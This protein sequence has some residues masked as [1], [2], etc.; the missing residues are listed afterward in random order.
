M[1]LSA[2]L[3]RLRREAGAVPAGQGRPAGDVAD[4][5]ARLRR[6]GVRRAGDG[7]ADDRRLA[8]RLGGERI[9]PGLVRLEAR[10]PL[11]HPGLADLPRC[12]SGLPEAHR[13][14]APDWVM[15]DTETTGLAGGT[16][17]VVF[18]LGLARVEAGRLR[19]CQYLLSRLAGEGA[20][21][22]Q[23]LAWLGEAA[24]LVSYNGKTFDLPL[25][26]TR[27]R[28]AGQ[29]PEAW[30][31]PHLDLLHGVR[32]CHGDHWP[33]CRLA[34]AERRLLGVQR[35]HDLPGSEAPAAWLAWLRRGD[36]MP[37]RRVLEHNRQDLVSLAGLLPVLAGVQRGELRSDAAPGRIAR[38]WLRH[39]DSERARELLEAG[40]ARLDAKERRLLLRLQRRAS[41]ADRPPQALVSPRVR[42]RE[43]PTLALPF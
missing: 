11:P 34:T 6:N 42:E 8:E 40:A 28:L 27:A 29:S 32:R 4:R 36:P 39:G 24:G 15:L 17:T 12:L 2:R 13:L 5:L 30:E 33:D 10:L 35:R 25:L 23:G 38:A 43:S 22:E 16:G 31:R 41:G 3:D 19:L 9:A 14:E 1:S 21:L 20:L 37:L 26:R 7:G 18:L